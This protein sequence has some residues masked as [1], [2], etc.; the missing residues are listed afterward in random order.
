[1]KHFQTPLI[2]FVQG[3][4]TKRI[5]IG[6]T[7]CGVPERINRLQTGSP[8]ELNFLGGCFSP[9][10]SEKKLHEMF[11]SYRLHGEWFSPSKEIYDFIEKNCFKNIF[12]LYSAYEELKAGELTY[13]KAIKIGDEGLI[14]ISDQKTRKVVEWLY[15]K[16]NTNAN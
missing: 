13:E 12:A 9:A 10:P 7:S 5:K 11:K 1:M 15:I 2:Y 16:E 3:E 8:D 6:E 4:I 14:N